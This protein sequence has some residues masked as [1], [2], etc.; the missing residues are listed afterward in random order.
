METL[1]SI[2]PHYDRTF[3]MSI[4][5]KSEGCL[6]TAVSLVL[7]EVVRRNDEELLSH[8]TDASTEKKM[9]EKFA[10]TPSGQTANETA[11]GKKSSRL[12]ISAVYDR[13]TRRSGSSSNDKNIV[14]HLTSP[15]LCDHGSSHV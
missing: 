11:T 14:K 12:W 9:L 5:Q 3:L 2:F 7:N 10:N 1:C 15:L 13:I 6:E 8:I 4:L